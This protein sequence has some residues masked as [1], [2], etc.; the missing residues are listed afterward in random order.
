MAVRKKK[1]SKKVTEY[2]NLSLRLRVFRG[3]QN[4][5][6]PGKAE[7]L[8][9]IIET[10]SLR[11]AANRMEMS[12]MKAW[13]LVKAMNENF[14]HPLVLLSRGGATGGSAIVTDEGRQALACYHD[15]LE[16]GMTATL[17]SWKKLQRLLKIDS[18]KA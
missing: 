2:W 7:L 10:G 14:A 3:G 13:L 8:E 4:S 18:K 6:G 16:A 5:F 17:P 12:Y 15:M 11:L 1:A 9:H